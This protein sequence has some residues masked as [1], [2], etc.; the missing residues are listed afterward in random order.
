MLLNEIVREL[1]SVFRIHDFSPDLPFS[2]LVPEVYRAT[3][4]VLDE[5]LEPGYLRRFHGLMVRNG[6]VINKVFTLVFLSDEMLETVASL[7]AKDC[8]IFTH[9]PLLMETSDRGFLPLSASWFTFMIE[10]R[11]SIYSLHT[12]L[13][14]HPEIST[15]KALC[16][17]LDLDVKGSWCPD[18]AGSTGLW[19]SISEPKSLE[20]FL[21][22]VRHC[23]DVTDL[24]FIENH[25]DVR[26]VAVRPGGVSADE[27]LEA[28]SLGCDTLVTGVYNNLVHNNIGAW[29]RSEFD[30]IRDDIT[31]NLIECSHY[32]SEA[33]VMR[34]DIVRLCRDLGVDGEFLPQ[35]EPWL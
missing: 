4:I 21:D 25:C 31:G 7:K 6:D 3:D 8:M 32:A 16:R 13:D 10:N 2:K 11:I 18:P 23:T 29:Y 19:G 20:S 14:V 35:A 1:D 22:A 28:Q 33:I 5:F 34:K 26:T 24:R 15:T 30:K 17:E 12:P 9:H 27:I